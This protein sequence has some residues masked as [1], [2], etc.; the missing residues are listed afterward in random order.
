MPQLNPR[1]INETSDVQWT[2]TVNSVHIVA[3]KI[4][5]KPPGSEAWETIATGTNTDDKDDLGTFK[6]TKGTEFSYWYGIGSTQPNTQYNIDIELQQ[7]GIRLVNGAMNE[8]D[9]VNDDGVARVLQ[10]VTLE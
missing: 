4:W 1:L 8:S 10:I 6:A 2:V 7:D 5:I 9:M 3:Y